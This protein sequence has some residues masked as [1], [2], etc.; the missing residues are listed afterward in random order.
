MGEL[1]ALL[2]GAVAFRAHGA[3]LRLPAKLAGLTAYLATRGEAERGELSETF[4]GRGSRHNLRVAL[5][6][7]RRVVPPDAWIADLSVRGRVGLRATSDVAGFERAV[8]DGRWRDAVAAWARA[9]QGRPHGEVFMGGF[10]LDHA[11]GFREWLGAE[12]ARLGAT[13][14][15]ALWH[16]AD[17]AEAH[18]D[19]PN[20]RRLW[21]TLLDEDPLDERACRR[22]MALALTAHDA[23]RALDHFDACRRVLQ[24][25]LGVEPSAATIALADQARRAVERRDT[26]VTRWPSAGAGLVGRE[27]TLRRLETLVDEA[28][29]LSLT[30]PG[31]IGKSHL[32]RAFVERVAQRY[33]RVVV[34]DVEPLLTAEAVLFA[35]A[36]ALGVGGGSR[37]RLLDG[38]R[39]RL[40]REA[41]LLVLDGIEP[42]HAVH[43]VLAPLLDGV[44]YGR[45]L[46]T[47]REPLGLP[48]ETC[49]GVDRL[50][51]PQGTRWRA[52]DAARVFV[53]A[54]ARSRPGF[55]LAEAD[56]AAFE[57][58][59][60]AVEGLPL[61]LVLAASLVSSFPLSEIAR[62]AVERPGEL[63][64]EA[65]TGVPQ[66]HRSLDG[67]LAASFAGLDPGAAERLAACSVFAG[68]FDHEGAVAVAG[69]SAGELV[70]WARAGW[71]H[72]AGGNTWLLHARVRRFLVTR[73][74]EVAAR[75]ARERH[76][77]HYLGRLRAAAPALRTERGALVLGQLRDAWDEIGLAWV[78]ADVDA[79]GSVVE[80]VR[81]VLDVDARHAEA[82]A[83]LRG[84]V[85]RRPSDASV[86]AALHAALAAFEVRV[87]QRERAARRA[88]LALGLAER[89]CDADHAGAVRLLA[90]EVA[91]ERG[92]Y[93]E[94]EALL[95]SIAPWRAGVA[96]A[97]IAR[98]RLRG[99]V[100]LGRSRAHVG[101][102]GDVEAHGAFLAE[103][104][105]AF[106]RCLARARAAGDA[107]A[108]AEA[109]HDVGFCQYVAGEY[110]AALATFEAAERRHAAA[111]VRRRRYIETYWIGI[112]SI[113]LGR[114]DAADAALRAA[115]RAADAAGERPKALEVVQG[116]GFLALRR[117]TP[118]E[119]AMCFAAALATPGLDPR[120]EAS[121]REW[122]LPALREVIGERT[123]RRLQQQAQRLGYR[124]VVTELVRSG[125][126]PLPAGVSP[127]P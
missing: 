117:G 110:D 45:C 71:L 56:R 62:I 101:G 30:G 48:F 95:E 74:D 34:V 6:E 68:R 84:A 116:F 97:T 63:G 16:A 17:E 92:R 87:G 65:A 59:V 14:L 31:G 122:H 80:V 4:W 25:E 66:R 23:A 70:R 79:L 98:E 5:H 99:L 120:V 114:F 81:T 27:R 15:R 28:L 3:V 33:E 105:A 76:A 86:A 127:P 82:I 102:G 12:R 10:E 123:W 58:L 100:A 69:T 83:L 103:S 18:D 2:L 13:Y 53:A 121:V 38:A 49:V 29:P 96:A 50:A 115:L 1:E 20:A 41:V 26:V 78:S 7:L 77:E 126:V 36:T 37:E 118:L 112:A 64:G 85:R 67:L 113:M 125:A 39:E 88:R 61:G 32:A 106:E 11:P 111:G 94:A 124:N 107:M 93:D 47:T 109:L 40:V 90:S 108:E 57:T 44:P 91:Y 9:A 119:A 19:A 60:G 24:R 52:S 46:A 22:A 54:A 75:A 42:R 73:L 72:D 21:E 43:G 89:A 35:V 51:A 104:L 55:A 8:A